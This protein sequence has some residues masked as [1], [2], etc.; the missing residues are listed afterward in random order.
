MRFRGSAVTGRLLCATCDIPPALA[1]GQG[2]SDGR[3]PVGDVGRDRG[4]VA[5]KSRHGGGGPDAGGGRDGADT[6]RH[7]RDAGCGKSAAAR[8]G[9]VTIDASPDGGPPTTDGHRT[10]CPAPTGPRTCPASNGTAALRALRRG[11]GWPVRLPDLHGWE[12]RDLGALHGGGRLPG[13]LDLSSSVASGAVTYDPVEAGRCLA[14]FQSD[15]CH[16]GNFLTLPDAF[17]V[18]VPVPARSR[19]RAAPASACVTKEECTAGLYCKKP[20]SAG[21]PTARA[22]APRSSKRVAACTN[23]TSR[24]ASIVGADV[25]SVRPRPGRVCQRGRVSLDPAVTA[26]ALVRP[27]QPHLRAA[28]GGGQPCGIKTPGRAAPSMQIPALG[29][30]VRCAVHRSQGRVPQ[31]GRRRIA[32]WR[33]LGPVRDRAPL[34][35]VRTGCDAGDVR[36]ARGVRRSVQFAGGMRRLPFLHRQRLRRPLARGG[37]VR[38]SS[39]I[40]SKASRVIPPTTTAA[41]RAI[42]AIR[43]AI[44]AG[45]ARE[46]ICR[47]GHCVD[48]AGIGEPCVYGDRLSVGAGLL[49]RSL[50]RQL[51]LR[52]ALSRARRGRHQRAVSAIP[53]ASRV[54]SGASCTAVASL[55][56]RYSIPGLCPMRGAVSADPRPRCRLLGV[57]SAFLEVVGDGYLALVGRGRGR[58]AGSWSGSDSRWRSRV[59]RGAER[60]RHGH[61]RAA[62]QNR[63]VDILFMVDDSSSMR[64]AQDS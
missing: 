22:N 40:V 20:R 23:A 60:R 25:P 21:L 7:D 55:G 31:A 19:P 14:R 41:S 46:S 56:I 6:G 8:D 37:R 12:Y 42:P 48:F 50:P 62:P 32:V 11:D 34:R 61:E 36:R 47:D 59:R 26:E 43:A 35:R 38:G 30:V 18:S 33:R 57:V 49:A 44:P 54:N 1:D 24:P 15:P 4:A 28:C 58:H 39:G 27:R 51:D 17:Q 13:R 45:S 29:V 2:R 53:P 9:A 16:F 63:N 52:R 3:P 5:V 64:L 10:I